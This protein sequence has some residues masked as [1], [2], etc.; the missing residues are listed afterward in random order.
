MLTAHIVAPHADDFIIDA[1]A[2]P[3]GKTTHLAALTENRGRIVAVD[4]SDA[5][6]KR[7]ADNAKRLGATAVETLLYDARNLGE[8]FPAAADAV[9]VDAPCSGLGVL[10]RKA[11]LRHK[12][13]AADLAR[14]PQTQ[15]EILAGAA[16]A[17]KCGGALIYSTCTI[18][19]TE[20][21]AVVTDFLRNNDDFAIVDA[22]QFLPNNVTAQFAALDKNA[23]TLPEALHFYPHRDK[24]DGFFI[25]KMVRRV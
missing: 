9:L 12:K 14:L 2:A 4:V 25:A 8:R 21:D 20:N 18:N 3:G 11:D 19:A 16:K 13:T 5:K 23:A 24:T 6:L 15:G 22:R 7:I 1:C 17:V 10:R